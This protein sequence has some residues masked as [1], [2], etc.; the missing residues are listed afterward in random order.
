MSFVPQS[1]T[2]LSEKARAAFRQYLPGTDAALA[3]NTAYVIAKVMALMGR[4]FELR[5]AWIYKQLFL[6]TATSETMVRL[7]AREFGLT[8]KPAAFARG[9][10]EGRADAHATYPA[11]VRFLSGQQS[12]VTVA[13]FTANAL[14]AFGVEVR[15][16]QAGADGNRAS[17]A[18]MQVADAG[19]YPAMTDVFA[20]PEGLTGGTSAETLEALRARALRVKA[21]P[22]QGVVLADYETWALEVPGIAAAWAAL[23]ENGFGHVGIWIVTKA[24]TN[25]IPSAADLAKV[26]AHIEDKRLVRGKVSAVAPFAKP[27]DLTI[28]LSPDTAQ[29]RAAVTAALVALFDPVAD[30][31]RLRPGLP[32]Q[33]FDLP[34]A[35]ISEVISAVEGETSH[36]IIAPAGDVTFQ[37]G[38]LPVLGTI[39]WA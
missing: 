33:P 39:D 7:H 18:A 15:A 27:L 26:E 2:V 4:E 1:L 19:L 22:P 17:G 38:E 16:E 34:V 13:S 10:V 25:G 24:G 23:F 29:Q 5:L 28:R 37:P 30:L 20:G 11:G 21:A 3:Q 6:T 31:P 35:W 36:T 8:P 12:Y 14:G 9:V 32:G